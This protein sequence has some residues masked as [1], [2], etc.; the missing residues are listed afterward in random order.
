MAHAG[1]PRH[2]GPVFRWG[3]LVARATL[4]LSIGAAAGCSSGEAPGDG[5][6]RA[7]PTASVEKSADPTLD[8]IVRHVQEALADYDS[9][10]TG[11]IVLV[12]TGERTRVLT[13]GMAD[14]GRRTRMTPGLRFPIQSITKPMVATVVLQLVA[15][16]ELRLDDTVE[17]VLPGLL[18]QGHRITVRHLLSHRAGLY[19]ATGADVP[20]PARMTQDSL[21]E[22]AA[23]HPL[24]FA[25][26]SS[27]RYSNVGYEVLGRIVEQ[28]TRQPLSVALARNVF[29][30]AGMSDSALLGSTD[31]TGYLDSKAVED[32]Y[33][34]FV[35]ASGGVVSTVRDV[36]R[37]FTALW[38]G[39]LLDPE[40]VE[41]M[42]EPQGFVS[43]IN[44]DYGLGVW[45]DRESCGDA[46][47]HSGAGPGFSTKAWT[48]PDRRAVVVMVNDGDGYTIANN[49]A[50]AVLCP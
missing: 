36:D 37:F 49:L 21:I 26:G 44:A 40:L 14:V 2:T 7:A 16:R 28:V 10:A 20:P 25:P 32:P 45:F 31:V 29:G 6:P 4:V 48:L 1:R 15:D 38:G 46:M 39:E 9:I 42:T 30:P 17:D 19:D 12:R 35:R 13:S 18:P 34:R 41:A 11:A 23:D 3:L 50:T 47:G 27:G 33:I 24:E 22:V 5:D 8:E 43:P